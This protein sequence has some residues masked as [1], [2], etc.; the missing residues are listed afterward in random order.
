MK[1]AAVLFAVALQVSAASLKVKVGGSVEEMPLEKYVAAVLAGEAGVF[2]S[3]EA[4]K[5]MAVIART[6]GMR[7]RGRHAAEGFD[8]CATTHCQRIDPDAVTPRLQRIAE[9]TAGEMLWYRGKLAFTPYS[10]DCGGRTEDVEA[11][12]P[13]ERAPYLKSHA[14]EYCIRAGGGEWHW[15]GDPA[16]VAAAL[17]KEGL[18][19]PTRITGIR[20]VE[21]TASGRARRL[22]LVGDRDVPI[23]AGALRFAIGRELGWNTLRSDWFDVRGTAFSGRGS[24]HGVGLCQRGADQMGAEG[25]GY[26]EIL[27]YSFPGTEPGVSA[28]GFEWTRLS[29]EGIAMYTTRPSQDG[30]VLA[31]AER[32]LRGDLERTGWAAPSGIEVRLYPDVESFRNATGEPGWVAAYTHGARI[33][34]Q[35]VRDAEKTLRHELFHV[36]IESQ[37][38]PSLP[39]WFREGLVEYL[40]GAHIGSGSGRLPSNAELRETYDAAGARRAY[41]DATA[42]VAELGRHYGEAALLRWVKSGIPSSASRPAV[43]SK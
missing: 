11:V 17:R 29:G 42:A 19:T 9:T 1:R 22:E 26:R 10:L 16:A 23:A 20:V 7:M 14:D 36:L 43:N 28:R 13:D 3:D 30:A 6:Y 5:A 4:L 41:E 27:A 38:A 37:A 12:W 39:R 31:A 25:R 21:R 33:E 40:S 32:A 15:I 35:P 18:Q 34:M 2:R 24:G 8:L